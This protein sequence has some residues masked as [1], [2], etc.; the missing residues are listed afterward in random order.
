MEDC[1]MALWLLFLRLITHPIG[2]GVVIALGLGAFFLTWL[3]LHDAKVADRATG[4]LVTS[5][6]SKDSE[7]AR[8]AAAAV[9]A[10][11]AAELAERQRQINEANTK[12]LPPSAVVV[13]PLPAGTAV[14]SH[15]PVVAGVRK[16]ANKVRRPQC[17]QGLFGCL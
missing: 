5:I 2:Q 17:E 6:S 7:D 10:R 15:P 12:K 1:L 13:P 8:K 14:S 16:P 4:K 3:A 9:A 11:N